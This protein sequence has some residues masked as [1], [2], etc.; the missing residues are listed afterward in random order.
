Y[1][2]PLMETQ[3]F[4]ATMQREMMSQI[5]AAAPAFVVRT[6]WSLGTTAQSDRTIL[7]WA[8]RYVARC[9]SLVGVVDIYA[10]DGTIQ[11]WGDALSSYQPRS[12]DLV[13]TY[14]RKTEAPCAG[15]P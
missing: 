2:Y 4:A 11:L 1:L 14:R 6:T 8:D 9:Y 12:E 5:E 10:L 3:P 7:N 15:D 13:Y